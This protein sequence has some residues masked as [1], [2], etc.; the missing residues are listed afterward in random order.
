MFG[1]SS[2]VATDATQAGAMALP[3]GPPHRRFPSRS[4]TLQS[5]R[6]DLETS[7]AL[8]PVDRRGM[9]EVIAFSKDSRCSG[10]VVGTLAVY[11][12]P[13]GTSATASNSRSARLSPSRPARRTMK[14]NRVAGSALDRENPNVPAPPSRHRDGPAG[15]G[16]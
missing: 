13:A 9:V 12:T 4:R 1:P 5:T 3:P 7:T 2:H 11:W 8:E 15:P 16:S 6:R 10:D 14:V